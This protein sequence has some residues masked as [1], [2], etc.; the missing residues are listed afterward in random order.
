M[1]NTAVV[2]VVIILILMSCDDST[3]TLAQPSKVKHG[4][5]PN[6]LLNICIDILG[7]Q[8]VTDS[9]CKGKEKC[10]PQ[11]CGKICADPEK[12]RICPKI[13][14]LDPNCN[15]DSDCLPSQICCGGCCVRNL[16]K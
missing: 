10:C 16:G 5:C 12:P 9:D 11:A 1:K 7:P 6:H 15:V 8:C 2:T 3:V 14:C 4:V 13:L